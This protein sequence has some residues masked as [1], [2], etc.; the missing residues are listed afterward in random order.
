MA[1]TTTRLSLCG[2]TQERKPLVAPTRGRGD[3][4]FGLQGG[5]ELADGGVRV[6]SRSDDEETLQEGTLFRS[7]TG[8]CGGVASSA[9]CGWNTGRLI[10]GTTDGIPVLRILATIV[11][12]PRADVRC[13]AAPIRPRTLQRPDVLR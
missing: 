9:R 13:V 5:D 8:F 1:Q 7:L 10:M 11:G 12:R 4:A 3:A 6:W 2:W